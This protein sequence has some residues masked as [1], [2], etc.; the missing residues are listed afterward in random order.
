MDNLGY[1]NP[2]VLSAILTQTS[3]IKYDEMQTDQGK[4]NILSI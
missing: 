1:Q 2:R 4:Y 3:E